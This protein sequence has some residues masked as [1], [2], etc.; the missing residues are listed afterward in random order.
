MKMIEK[1]KVWS[2]HIILH[3]WHCC[4]ICKPTETTTDE[5]ALQNM[6]H[7][8]TGGECNHGELEEHDLPWFD[9]RDKD[10]E[11]LQK[12]ILDPQVLG[13]F[14]YYVRFRHT[15]RIECAN[16]LSLVY[17]PKRCSYSYKVYKARKQL[18]AIDWNFHM[19]LEAATTKAG[20]S[21]EKVQYANK[22]LGCENYHSQQKV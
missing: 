3:F 22:G 9:R 1:I 12:V 5:Q 19:N 6:K 8:W 10:F 7:E 15:G 16:S 13:S 2:E 4:S 11:A 17:T 18:A 14:K 20:D 21:N